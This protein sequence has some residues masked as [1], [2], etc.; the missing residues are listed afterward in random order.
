MMKNNIINDINSY[1]LEFDEINKILLNSQMPTN[2]IEKIKIGALHAK[3]LDVFSKINVLNDLLIKYFNEPY[4]FTEVIKNE[5]KQY[6][7]TIECISIK[8][9]EVVFSKEYTDIIYKINGN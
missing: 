9:G 1:I 5:I 2:N 3:K 8:N 6:K 7:K 4:E